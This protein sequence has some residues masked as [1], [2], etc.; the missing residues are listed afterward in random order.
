MVLFSIMATAEL[1]RPA[2]PSEDPKQP[3]VV[4][5]NVSISFDRNEVLR[6]ISFKVMPGESRIVLGP[7][8]CGKSVLLK[9]AN[10]LLRPDSGRIFVFGNE[11]D[12]MPEEELF[13][14]R[15]RI[16]MV[17]QEGALF[18]SMTVRDNVAYR[19]I[20][21]HASAEDINR[22]VL[23]VLRF[24][25][26][27][28]TID[29]YP[30]ELSGGMRRRVAIARAIVSKPD[31]LLYDSPTGG[32]DPITSTTIIELV[33]KQRD[34][35]HTSS[36]LVTH[37]LQ[38]AFTMATHYFDQQ[39]N[40]MVPLPDGQLDPQTSFLMLHDRKLVFDGTTEEL[41][42]STDPFIKDY[43]E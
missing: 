7:A 28:H 19:L 12:V 29:K 24:V 37:R 35:S 39:Q 15:D 42:H 11:I 1:T 17:F 31:L 32:L 18:D 34:V 25:E 21:E 4:F 14:L 22:R 27:E 3:V 16:G 5:E 23:E 6:D 30:S 8:G 20:E 10:G 40:K 9:L 33:V 26:L 41:V 36:L 13:K 38:D 43:L 2:A